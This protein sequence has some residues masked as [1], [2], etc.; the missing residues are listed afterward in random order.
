MCNHI[1]SLNSVFG[2]VLKLYE[3]PSF[4]VPSASHLVK[5]GLLFLSVRILCHV[6]ECLHVLRTLWAILLEFKLL[7]GYKGE[8]RQEIILGS[9]GWRLDIRLTNPYLKTLMLLEIAKA[10]PSRIRCTDQIVISI[11]HL[12]SVFVFSQFT[13]CFEECLAPGIPSFYTKD[14]SQVDWTILSN[15]LYVY[16]RH[17]ILKITSYITHPHGQMVSKY[18]IRSP[19]RTWSKLLATPE[20]N[21]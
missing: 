3:W 11:L 2:F 17:P 5:F 4:S 1:S 12:C 13:K 16:D 8:V 15:N 18:W 21:P 14:S 9:S 20:R 19:L 6:K 7:T 10:L